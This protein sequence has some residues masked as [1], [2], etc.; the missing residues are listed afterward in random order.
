M[1]TRSRLSSAAGGLAAPAILALSL[2]LALGACG[3]GS[4]GA[5]AGG[6]SVATAPA[7]QALEFGF[8]PPQAPLLFSVDVA[9][10]AE[11]AGT[12]YISN[13]RYQW[14]ARDWQAEGE[15]WTCEIRFSK[16]SAG[17]RSGGGLTMESQD[18]V[19]RLE[20]FSTR[21][22]KT[23]DGFEPVTPPAKD[24]E[25]L[26]VFEQLQGGLAP[27]DF[28]A[29]A[30]AMRVGETW[31]LPLRGRAFAA[32]RPA[33][34]DSLVTYTYSGDESYQGRACARLQ[35]QA[36]FELDG[37]V[38]GDAADAE[39]ASALVRGRIE[40]QASGL[41][42]KAQGFLV[43]SSAKQKFVINQREA[44]AKGE[45]TGAEQ[46]IVQNVNL[47]IKLLSG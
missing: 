46:S 22:R 17:V 9:S 39:A 36:K 11:V 6:P 21:Y 31:Q 27:L 43:Q 19:K 13:L 28:R 7:G 14:E 40:L 8:H 42:D 47:T 38:T 20:G 37:L 41:Y 1:M 16:L 2:A 45:A 24:K 15:D 34:K 29:P 3:G 10:E 26:A 44:N 18:V 4:V 12:S 30:T 5:G 23:K 33:M 25:F 32:L 35:R